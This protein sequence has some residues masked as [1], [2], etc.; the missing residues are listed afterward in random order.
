MMANMMQNKQ[1]WAC[2]WR[3][4]MCKKCW[5]KRQKEQ[6]SDKEPQGT[7]TEVGGCQS[8]HNLKWRSQGRCS[9]HWAAG[10]REFIM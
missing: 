10:W 2:D 1:K 7:I 3:L 4:Q 5:L 6:N 9:K 8:D